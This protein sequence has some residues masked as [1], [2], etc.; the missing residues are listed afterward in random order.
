MKNLSFGVLLAVLFVP[1]LAFA[2]WW[3]PFTWSMFNRHSVPTIYV[4]PVQNISEKHVIPSVANI[5]TATPQQVIGATSSDEKTIVSAN[6]LP[7]ISTSSNERRVVIEKDLP[8]V[9]KIVDTSATP[10]PQ[11]M[12]CNGKNWVACPAG[13]SFVCPPNGDASCQSPQLPVA[14]KPSGTLCNG[15]YWSS[16]P[17]GQDLVCPANGGEAYCQSQQ[18][19]PASAPV[20]HKSFAPSS[21]TP[22]PQHQDCHT[23]ST[24]YTWDGYRCVAPAQMAPNFSGTHIDPPLETMTLC[25]YDSTSIICRQ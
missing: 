9:K 3:N 10:L 25:T 12:F 13:Q 4:A 23:G 14:P 21:Y 15:T 5:D 20:T 18:Q 24:G 8:A 11:N 16:C 7:V 1:Q 17:L 6:A 19:V 22:T 2:A